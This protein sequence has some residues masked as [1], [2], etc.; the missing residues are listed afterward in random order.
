LISLLS[1]FTAIIYYEADYLL[2]YSESINTYSDVQNDTS[3][4]E[5][6]AGHIANISLVK[7]SLTLVSE[8]S[9]YLL[10]FL[11]LLTEILY[12]LARKEHIEWKKVIK[13]MTPQDNFIKAQDFFSYQLNSF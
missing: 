1:I 3:S 9:S 13:E 2:L 5:I 6:I 10:F 11:T 4:Q 7:E 8:S 12:A